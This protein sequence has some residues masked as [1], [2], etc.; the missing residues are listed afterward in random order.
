MSL[1]E[2]VDLLAQEALL[3]DSGNLKAC[4]KM[5]SLLDMLNHPDVHRETAALREYLEAMIM[6]EIDGSGPDINLVIGT[7]ETIQHRLQ[8]VF[9]GEP[10]RAD[11]SGETDEFPPEPVPAPVSAPSIAPA[12]PV[13]DCI[14]IMEEDTGLLNDFI[15]EAQEHLH[16][17]EINMVEWE[18]NPDDLEIV[19]SIFRPFHTIKGVS[20]FL[21]LQEINHLSHQLENLLD[22]ARDGRIRHSPEFSDLIFDGVDMLRRMLGALEDAVRNCGTV[23]YDVDLDGMYGRLKNFQKGGGIPGPAAPEVP[24]PRIGDILVSR[25]V[26]HEEKLRETL[27]KQAEEHPE[28]PLGEILIE[29]NAVTPREV[30]DA[31]RKQTEFG[32]ATAERSIKVDTVKLDQLLDM[33]G[34]LVIAQSMVTHNDEVKKIADPQFL[35]DIVQLGRVTATL[36]SISMSMRLV[37]VGATFQKMNRIVRDIARKAGK[38]INLVIEG[39]NAEIDRNMVEELYDPL[40]HMIRNACD[41]GIGAPEVRKANGKPEEGTVRLSAEHSGGKVIITI[42][43][44]GNG[45]NREAILAKGIERGLVKPGERPTDREIDNLIFMPGFSTAKQIT[46]ISGRGVGMD[47]VRKAL[48]KLR[49]TVEPAS[50]PG[51]GTTFTIKLPLTTAIIDGMLVRVG[52]E[53]YIIPTLSVRRIIRPEKDDLSLIVGKG[54]IVRIKDKLIPIIRLEEVLGVEGAVTDPLESVLIIVEDLGREVA[55]RADGLIGKQEI[56]IKNLGEKF[57]DLRGVAGGAIL[58]DGKIGLILDIRAIVHKNAITV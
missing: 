44:D 52:A 17:I 26:I 49:G 55:F 18:K 53:R 16:A 58:G 20:G 31:I 40:V 47:V 34:E 38:S 54:E 4:G 29:E 8:G 39:Q 30:R 36:Q 25:G 7:V 45:L 22:D 10:G 48:E 14:P 1:T 3:L 50:V 43:D 35:R 24:P 19:N 37:P 56:V 27:R 28:K 32:K 21:N 12:A 11:E 9:S 6:N 57:K 2:I 41:H 5:L 42:S 23:S 33:V 46:E 15:M 13:P 51:K